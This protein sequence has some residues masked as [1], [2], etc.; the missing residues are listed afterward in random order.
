MTLPVHTDI[1]INVETH[2]L[3]FNLGIGVRATDDFIAN[4]NTAPSGTIY[5]TAFYKLG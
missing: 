3:L 2:G 5:A 1:T 4:D